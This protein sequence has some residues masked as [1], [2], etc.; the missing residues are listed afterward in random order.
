M[1][2]FAQAGRRRG[3]FG[4]SVRTPGYGDGEAAPMGGPMGDSP[5]PQKGG[6]LFGRDSAL[7]KVLGTFGDAF[8]DEGPPIYTQNLLA[9]Q[10]A[11]DETAQYERQRADKRADWQYEQDYKRDNPEPGNPYRF[12]DNAGNVYERGQDGQN[13]LIFTDPNDKVYMQDGQMITVPNRVRTQQAPAGGMPQ[14]TDEATYN[15]I[16]P[17]AQ[18]TTPDG[19]VRVKGGAAAAGTPPFAGSGFVPPQRLA[20]GA[21]TSGRR[22]PEGNRLVGGVPKSAHLDG[23]AADYDGPNL[24]ALLGEARGLPGVRKAFIH[25]GHVHTE[26]EG[27]SAPYYGKRGTKGLKR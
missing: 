16:P 21:M 23:R 18:Y 4:S 15:A 3:L 14:V 7:W 20:N 5:M 8:N 17:G 9:K 24:N 19:S 1:L 13:N 26:G 25:D 22:T 27:W 6:G 10:R 12:E 2:Q 11:Q